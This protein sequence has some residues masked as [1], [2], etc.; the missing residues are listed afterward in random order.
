MGDKLAGY[1]RG[2]PA[3]GLVKIGVRI[4]NKGGEGREGKTAGLGSVMIGWEREGGNGGVLFR[5][6]EDGTF[7]YPGTD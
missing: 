7:R 1:R 2:R 4:G 5:V 3:N 6:G